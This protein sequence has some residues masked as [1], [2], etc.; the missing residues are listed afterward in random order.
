[1]YPTAA[2]IPLAGHCMSDRLCSVD[3][4][5]RV[6][7]LYR[8]PTPNSRSY[9]AHGCRKRQPHRRVLEC[10]WATSLERCR[11]GERPCCEVRGFHVDARLANNKHLKCMEGEM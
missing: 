1:V 2:L 5:S 6:L 11:R 8:P 4:H 10:A 9:I 7:Q 3:M